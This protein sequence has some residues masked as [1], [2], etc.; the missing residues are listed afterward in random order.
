MKGR[1]VGE[2]S[3]IADRLLPPVVCHA[4]RPE[5]AEAD[6][7]S[8]HVGTSGFR[9]MLIERSPSAGALPGRMT[10][11]AMECVGACLV[12]ALAQNKCKLEEERYRS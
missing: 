4:S 5:E 9:T 2:R 3:S 8:F 11:L 6:R 1:L 7:L 10:T 12:V